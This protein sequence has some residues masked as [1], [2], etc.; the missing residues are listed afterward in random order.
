MH[1]R[2]ES[3]V[4]D[5]SCPANRPLDKNDDDNRKKKRTTDITQHHRQRDI[6]ITMIR[7]LKEDRYKNVNG[8]SD[9][10]VM[11]SLTQRRISETP[12]GSLQ[13]TE[14]LNRIGSIGFFLSPSSSSSLSKDENKDYQH[15]HRR[16]H[17]G[18]SPSSSG[19]TIVSRV[20]GG[21]EKEITVTTSINSFGGGAVHSNRF[22]GVAGMVHFCNLPIDSDHYL[23]IARD[24]NLP[25]NPIVAIDVIFDNNE[26]TS[27]LDDYSLVATD[28]YTNISDRKT[29]IKGNCRS[30][31]H[32]TEF[33]KEDKE[34]FVVNDDEEVGS[35]TL[36]SPLTKTTPKQHSRINTPHKHY[37]SSL[38][39][40]ATFQKKS[41]SSK[42]DI[43]TTM[44]MKEK[45]KNRKMAKHSFGEAMTSDS[46]N[47]RFVCVEETSFGK[48]ISV[49]IME[50][51]PVLDW[52]QKT[53]TTNEDNRIGLASNEL[54]KMKDNFSLSSSSTSSFSNDDGHGNNQE[55]ERSTKKPKQMLDFSSSSSSGDNEEEGASKK[56]GNIHGF[57]L[58]CFSS[59]SFFSD[60]EENE[61]DNDGDEEEDH[62]RCDYFEYQKP[63]ILL[64]RF[65]SVASNNMDRKCNNKMR[66][67]SSSKK[68]LFDK[69]TSDVKKEGSAR[70][71][72]YNKEGC[73]LTS[74]MRKNDSRSQKLQMLGYD[75]MTSVA[76]SP[77]YTSND[78]IQDQSRRV[79]L[80]RTRKER[81]MS[82]DECRQ[83]K[84]RDDDVSSCWDNDFDNLSIESLAC[85]RNNDDDSD[86]EEGNCAHFITESSDEENEIPSLPAMENRVSN[87]SDS[88]P[89]VEE[90]GEYTN[91]HLNSQ[92]AESR[93]YHLHPYLPTTLS[94]RQKFPF[95]YLTPRN[96]PRTR[97]PSFRLDFWFA[98][99]GLILLFPWVRDVNENHFDQVR[100]RK[101]SLPP[102]VLF[103]PTFGQ[104]KVYL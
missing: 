42:N 43:D 44:N 85:V 7:P 58:S 9:N 91:P 56:T 89:T 48:S 17:R 72:K 104:S 30:H 102:P 96:A 51:S 5:E 68:T 78:L 80:D 100:E 98:F 84:I 61:N 65:N 40:V 20:V 101:K 10:R 62:R 60:D 24:R 29:H 34:E 41:S 8:N 21:K 55:E 92:L 26:Q 35:I 31:L 53:T 66:P 64:D 4:Y 81:L 50:K 32:S 13:T 74:Q 67:T 27:D 28:S 14:N 77:K 83:N 69:F 86:D 95:Q 16:C 25:G 75:M 103:F 99:V 93:L 90:E 76:S 11:A 3:V 59:S 63:K 33:Q 97:R 47:D 6:G 12:G 39:T 23:L 46:D 52:H 38:R 71:S 45:K 82:Y 15:H 57:S 19:T 70:N 87:E 49:E 79:T 94:V 88:R 54:K 18:L 37:P 2:H 73:T 36:S 1:L 22:G